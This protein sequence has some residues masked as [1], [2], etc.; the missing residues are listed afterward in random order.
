MAPYL[1]PVCTGPIILYT[2]TYM[3]THT[4]T[5]ICTA[6]GGR[7]ACTCRRICD[8]NQINWSISPW[9]HHTYTWRPLVAFSWMLLTLTR[10]TAA[11]A[12]SSGSQHALL[13][14]ASLHGL[15]VRKIIASFCLAEK[16]FLSVPL[17]GSVLFKLHFFLAKFE[18]EIFL[19]PPPT[20]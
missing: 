17:E 14:S 13:A 19:P 16:E 1:V 12:R 18:K 6:H 9:K 15:Y 3:R 5:H 7:Q 10:G 20:T 4:W 11:G 2:R 8:Y